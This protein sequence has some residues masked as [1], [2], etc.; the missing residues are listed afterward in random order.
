MYASQ[1]VMILIDFG[2]SLLLPE[3]RPAKRSSLWKHDIEN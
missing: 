2:H 3:D 1:V